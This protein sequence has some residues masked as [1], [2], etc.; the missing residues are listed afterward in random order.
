MHITKNCHVVSESRRIHRV[1]IDNCTAL[2]EA[3]NAINNTDKQ[4][5][6][7]NSKPFE[8]TENHNK[9]SKLTDALIVVLKSGELSLRSTKSHKCE[10]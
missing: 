1:V 5:E 2:A 10:S 7:S 4:Y 8:S 9:R 6:S 3:V